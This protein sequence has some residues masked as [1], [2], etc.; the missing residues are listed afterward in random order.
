M[1][2]VRISAR[3]NKDEWDELGKR[4][5]W[6]LKQH[7]LTAVIKMVLDAIKEGGSSTMGA[8]IS[9]SYRL[10]PDGTIRNSDDASIGKSP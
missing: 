10:V 5:P 3:V 7:I 6:G 2:Q 8:I 1:T 4:V 9:G